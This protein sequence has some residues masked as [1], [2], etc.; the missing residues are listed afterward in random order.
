MTTQ[1]QKI[2]L[3]A[4]LWPAACKQQGWEARDRAKLYEIYARK[5]GHLEPHKTTLA[6]G[7]RISACDFVSG[8]DRDDFGEVKKELLLLAGADL[9][10]SDPVRQRRLWIIEQRLMPC[11]RLYK[12]DG[13][14]TI[15]RERFGRIRNVNTI[16]DLSNDNLEKLIFTLEARINTARNEAG[17]SHHEMCHNAGVETWKPCAKECYLCAPQAPDNLE[18]V[19]AGETTTSDDVP[20]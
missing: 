8:S 6:R 11:Y 4:E 10:E 9:L 12:A 14:E 13:L 18:T 7:G 15:L 5:L 2:H 17:D 20:F 3:N 1:K 16:H 19:P